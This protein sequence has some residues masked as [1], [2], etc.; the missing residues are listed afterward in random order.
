MP[1]SREYDAGKAAFG[2]AHAVK[3]AKQVVRH[4]VPNDLLRRNGCDKTVYNAAVAHNAVRNYQMGTVRQNNS[5]DKLVDNGVAGAVFGAFE[6]FL[7]RRSFG[8]GGGPLQVRLHA[9]PGVRHRRGP[10]HRH[11]LVPARRQQVA[12]SWLLDAAMEFRG[13]TGPLPRAMP[14][15]GADRALSRKCLSEVSQHRLRCAASPRACHWCGCKGVQRVL[16]S[17]WRKGLTRVVLHK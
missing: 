12:L 11:D 16:G 1:K 7:A 8:L 5:M 2:K 10:L 6:L 13:H 3:G 15:E 14:V 4:I 9:P 17:T